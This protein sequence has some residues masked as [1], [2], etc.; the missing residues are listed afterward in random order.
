MLPTFGRS[1]RPLVRA[2]LGIASVLALAVL[3]AGRV[4]PASTSAPS[5]SAYRASPSIAARAATPTPVFTAAP[6][7]T[8]APTPAPFKLTLTDADLTAAAAKSFPQTVNGVTVTDPVVRIN[9]NGVRLVA[10][11]RVF[12]GTTQF[13]LVGSPYVS[14]GALAVRVDS[15]TL[16]GLSLPDSVRTSI[17]QSLRATLTDLAPS[18]TT[19]RTVGLDPGTLTIEGTAR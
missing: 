19:I 1:A 18:S 7:A 15:A 2:G 13:V 4:S 9:A 12:F 8:P 17:A 14:D 11:A 10:S 6:T 5:P 3:L 16:G